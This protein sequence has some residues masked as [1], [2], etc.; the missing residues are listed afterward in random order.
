MKNILLKR[1]ITN[2]VCSNSMFLSNYDTPLESN[3]LVYCYKQ[4]EYS[5]YQ[6]SEINEDIL[7]CNKV[8][9]YPALFQ[10]MP[11]IPWA[12]IGVFRRGGLSDIPININTSEVHGKVLHVD[13]YL[14]TCPKNILNEK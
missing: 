14:L 13:K 11:E 10:E 8:G 7:T 2:H 5:I 6:I 4:K 3:N 9:Q 1:S 12:K